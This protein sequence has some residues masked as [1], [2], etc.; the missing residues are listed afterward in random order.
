MYPVNPGSEDSLH[1]RGHR[2]H[3][4]KT[5]Y[6]GKNLLRG[7]S[8]PSVLSVVKNAFALINVNHQTVHPS[9]QQK[10]LRRELP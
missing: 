1:H 8:V 6:C 2:E 3:R 4:E 9:I 7:F 5:K 10:Y